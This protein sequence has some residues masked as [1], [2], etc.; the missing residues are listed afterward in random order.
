MKAPD[1]TSSFLVSQSPAEVFKAVANV[2]GWW[3]EEIEGRTDALNEV[4]NYHHQD[5]HRTKMKIVEFVPDKKIV[6]HCEENNFNFT[7]D[8]KEWTGTTLVFEINKK[9]DQTEMV[10]THIGLVPTEECYAICSDCWTI[11]IQGSLKALIETGKGKPN[12]LGAAI[13]CAEN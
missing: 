12:R 4:F 13:E 8:A 3:S 10:F 9:G 2:R 6:W 11:Y 1:Y 7:K 5:I